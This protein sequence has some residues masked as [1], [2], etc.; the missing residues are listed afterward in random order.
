MEIV[1]TV[2]DLRRHTSEWRQA[3]LSSAVVPTMGG[4]HEGHLSLVRFGRSKAE[5]IVATLF[6]NPTQFAPS[7]D[8]AAY[9]RDETH[10]AD[11]LSATGCDLL[12]APDV[13]VMYP[14]GFST[15]VIVDGLTDCLCGAA[16]KGHFDGVSQVVTKLL[17]QAR[18]DFAIFGEKDWQQLQV[19]RRLASDLDIA[20][21][22]LAAPTIREEDG[23]AMSSRNRYL[24]T[25]ERKV[26]GALSEI[27]HQ[28][29]SWISQGIA[30]DDAS[31]GARAA[32][33]KAGFTDV[34]YA[35]ARTSETLASITT[36]DAAIPTRV[37]A[38]A[39]LGKARLIDNMAV[40]VMAT[41]S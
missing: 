15:R 8:L 40:P 9:P 10:D 37:F 1:R 11:M 20:T 36:F 23:L 7:E 38:A 14:P 5:R 25:E 21:E 13:G 34:D 24:T 30:P 35:E 28:M 29:A 33:I 41:N 18:A 27:L 6:V 26:A 2:E 3:G 12:F 17:N 22:I 4:L 19:V 39:H 16:R 31:E 32:L